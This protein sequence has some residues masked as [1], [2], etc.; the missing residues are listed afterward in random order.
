MIA[1]WV[2]LGF[3]VLA[4]VAGVVFV[5]VRVLETKKAV[6]SLKAALEQELKR[7]SQAGERTSSELETATL[8]FERLQ[9]SLVRLNSAR[10]RVRVLRDV[11]AEAEAVLARARGLV[12]SK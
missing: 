7:I 3:L 11:M 10:R 4:L 9:A 1:F 2:S 6:K 8:A 5:V 12:P